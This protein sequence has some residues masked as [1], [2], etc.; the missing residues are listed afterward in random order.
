[1]PPVTAVSLI[2]FMLF[3][4]PIQFLGGLLR[5]INPF[6]ICRF[7]GRRAMLYCSMILARPHYGLL[8][9]RACYLDL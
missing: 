4:L 8:N 1:M 2:V 7:G 6:Y 3:I 5:R 9:A